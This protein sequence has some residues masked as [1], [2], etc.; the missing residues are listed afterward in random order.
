MFT[1]LFSHADYEQ[2]PN[3]VRHF[4]RHTGTKIK[5]YLGSLGE[6]SRLFKI[7][8]FHNKKRGQNKI[9]Q[10]G[11]HPIAIK[12]GMSFAQKLNYVHFNPV[13]KG[14][15]GKPEYWQYSS[16]RNYMLGDKGLI[17][18]DRVELFAD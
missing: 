10:T 3:I 7:K 18:L 5:D 1:L 17:V 9:W 11:Y 13:K 4:K 14:F 6:V 16:A 15:V 2:I 12:S 8:I